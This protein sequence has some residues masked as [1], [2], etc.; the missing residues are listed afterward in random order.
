MKLPFFSVT[1]YL[2]RIYTKYM[3]TEYGCDFCVCVC[4][5]LSATFLGFLLLFVPSCWRPAVQLCPTRSRR[6]C[7]QPQRG[8]AC[9]QLRL[10]FLALFPAQA[11]PSF[12]LEPPALGSWPVCSKCLVSGSPA[13]SARRLQPGRKTWIPSCRSA[14]HLRWKCSSLLQCP[15]CLEENIIL[16]VLVLAHR[17]FTCPVWELLC[18]LKPLHQT[19]DFISMFLGFSIRILKFV[20][21]FGFF[22]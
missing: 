16:N 15:S 21:Y 12:L 11:L 9:W 7:Q 3:S 4:A 5:V 14:W 18:F 1:D 2:S 17:N 20:C 10:G 13:G 22:F 8:G 6:P 19:W